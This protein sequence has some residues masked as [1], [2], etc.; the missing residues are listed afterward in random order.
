MESVAARALQLRFSHVV[1][2]AVGGLSAKSVFQATRAPRLC[3]IQTCKKNERVAWRRKML[4]KPHGN[5]FV[6]M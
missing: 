6:A 3:H 4:I 2:V 1:G 5:F